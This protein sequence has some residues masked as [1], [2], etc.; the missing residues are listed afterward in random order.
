MMNTRTAYLYLG[1]DPGKYNR[2][3][4]KCAER[5]ANKRG[6]GLQMLLPAPASSSDNS[7]DSPF[8][9]ALHGFTIGV[10]RAGDYVLV[11]DVGATTAVAQ[12]STIKG[13]LASGVALVTLSDEREFNGVE[14]APAFS[15]H[16]FALEKKRRQEQLTRCDVMPLSL[17]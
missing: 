5:F 15:E 16:L 13:L 11:G 1:S 7:E 10:L 14:S 3:D 2:R 17:P 6:S 9:H 8:A 12:S 4:L